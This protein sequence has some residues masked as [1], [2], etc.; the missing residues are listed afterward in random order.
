MVG[1]YD[2]MCTGAVRDWSGW[3]PGVRAVGRPWRLTRA[4]AR[5][6]ELWRRPRHDRLRARAVLMAARANGYVTGSHCLGG[7]YAV[8]PRLLARHDLLDWRPWIRTQLGEDV[9]VGLLCAAAGLRGRS[10]VDPGEP[11]GLAHTGLPGEPAWLMERGHGIVHSLKTPEQGGEQRL[12]AYFRRHRQGLAT[13]FIPAPAAAAR[14][15]P[16]P[17]CAR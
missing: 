12:R 13:S 2:R 9:V 15:G 4:G 14:R 1:S 6:R 7:A 8:T 3:E 10:L 5:P 17:P 11:F 16:A